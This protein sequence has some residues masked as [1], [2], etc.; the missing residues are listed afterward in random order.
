M[1]PEPWPQDSGPLQCWSLQLLVS[2]IAGHC[3]RVGEVVPTP[4]STAFC[5][6]RLRLFFSLANF[7]TITFTSKFFC[8]YRYSL[9]FDF[10]NNSVYT[11]NPNLHLTEKLLPSRNKSGVKKQA[12]AMHW[13]QLY[14]IS[15]ADREGT[16]AHTLLPQGHLP[17]GLQE[18]SAGSPRALPRQLHRQHLSRRFLDPSVA[19]KIWA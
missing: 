13:E 4:F 10:S 11:R 16:G 8:I 5:T 14:P 7:C 19:P 3:S 2:T 18:P 15:D 17:T 12:C 6:W 9:F 1:H